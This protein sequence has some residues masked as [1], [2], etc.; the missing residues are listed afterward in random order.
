MIAIMLPVLSV[1]GFLVCFVPILNFI[2]KIEVHSFLLSTGSL[3]LSLSNNILLNI[4]KNMIQ[5]IIFK[6]K[7]LTIWSGKYWTL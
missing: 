4:V 5:D 7:E 6:L 3:N 1:C 2:Y